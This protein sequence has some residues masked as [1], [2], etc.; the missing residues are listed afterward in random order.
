[1]AIEISPRTKIKITIWTMAAGV[2]LAI[3]LLGL[4]VSY[5]YF[6]FN[7]KKIDQQIQEK[8]LAVAPLERAIKEK[9]KELIPLS[10]KIKDFDKLLTERKNIL[11]IFAFLERVCLPKVWFSKFEFD[12]EK[13]GVVISGKTDNFAILDQ[14]VS[15][16]KQEPLL[17]NFNISE[18]SISKEGEG[19]AFILLLAFNI[20]IFE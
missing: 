16:L 1:M 14:Q 19:I 20:S 13:R 6:F 8:T 3:L 18:V 9:E 4:L 12:A 7:I 15:I 2:V 10:E 5:F 11:N 17:E